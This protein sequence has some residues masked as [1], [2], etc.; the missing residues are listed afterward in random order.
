MPG[1]RRRGAGRTLLNA[2]REVTPDAWAT[3]VSVQTEPGNTTALQL[4][5][6][7]G[8]VPVEASRS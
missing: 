3:R 5:R 4:Y 2:V 1:P 8:F 7:S 6:T